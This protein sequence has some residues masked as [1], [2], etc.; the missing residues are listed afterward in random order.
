MLVDPLQ[1]LPRYPGS[2]L[3]TVGFGVVGA[4]LPDPLHNKRRWL[5]QRLYAPIL[6]RALAG[7][8]AQLI[9][10][11]GFISFINQ[12][13][14]ELLLGLARPS[15]WCP[16]TERYYPGINSPEEGWFG[17]CCDREDLRDDLYINELS[18]RHQYGG[19]LPT[20]LEYQ[21]K[22]YYEKEDE[23]E[24]LLQVLWDKAPEDNSTPDSRMD[25]LDHRWTLV[26]KKRVVWSRC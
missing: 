3:L 9:D 10:N 18:L 5:V 19:Y 25:T 12:Q 15:D 26:E 11:K 6:G 7:I 14:L 13:D 24:E 21:R 23:T 20:G 17:I 2:R 22:V 4:E 8:R 16:W 1:P